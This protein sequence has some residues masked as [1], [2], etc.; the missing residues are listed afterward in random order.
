MRRRIEPPLTCLSEEAF[1]FSSSRAMSAHRDNRFLMQAP[2]AVYATTAD[3][4]NIAYQVVGDR[5]LDLVFVPG[6]ISNVDL[7]WELPAT[8]RFFSRLA[9]FSRLI[10]FDKRGTGLSDPI[11]DAA[12]LEV[13]A[14]DL[15]TVMDAAGSEQ[16]AVCGYSEGAATAALFAATEPQ[17]LE[18][19]VPDGRALCIAQLPA[20]RAEQQ[21]RDRAQLGPGRPDG[22]LLAEPH[23]RSARPRR[24]GARAATVVH[25]RHG[26]QV[27]GPDG[28][29]ERG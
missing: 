15:R 13:R 4:T 1:H 28:T 14:N 18:A 26:A 22:A 7:F 2:E 23:G 24:L 29:A 25:A 3:G 10:V 11:D 16:A 19:G 9:S 20:L 27:L 12:T 8:R 17:R 21:G 6:W 5:P